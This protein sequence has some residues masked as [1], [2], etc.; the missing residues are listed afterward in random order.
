MTSRVHEKDDPQ[1]EVISIDAHGIWL[2]VKGREHVLP[3]EDFP[4]FR[5]AKVSEVL[6]VRLLRGAHLHW[7]ALD[8]DLSVESLEHPERFPLI[9]RTLAD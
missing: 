9:A 4:W 5:D 8:V 6:R 7:P 2:L 3:Y 1:A